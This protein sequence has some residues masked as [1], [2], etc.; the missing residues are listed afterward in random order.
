MK[1]LFYLFTFIFILSYNIQAQN[2]AL[3]LAG[4]D[5]YVSITDLNL[6]GFSALTFE[7]WVY[8]HTFNPQSPDSYISNILGQ[9]DESGLLRIG[10]DDAGAM[11]DNDRAQFVVKTTSGEKKCNGTT[12]MSTNRWY[13]LAGTYDGSNVKIY[14]NGVLEDTKAHSGNINSTSSIVLMG[15]TTSNNRYFDGLMDEVRI[16]SSSRTQEEIRQ[17]MYVELSDSEIGL[18]AYYKLNEVDGSTAVADAKGTYHGSLNNMSG[19]EWE[20]SSSFFGPKTCLELD[21]TDDYVDCGNGTG[22]QITGTEITLEAWINADNF[23]SNSHE[24]PIIDKH[25]LSVEGYTLRCGGSG[26]LSFNLGD[27]SSWYEVVSPTNSLSTNTWHHVAGVYD[28]TNMKIYVDGEEVNSGSTGASINDNGSNLSIGGAAE[29]PDR[30]FDGK[31]DE[32]R[33]W[34]VARSPSQIIE[35][36][37]NTLTGNESGLVAYYNFDNSSGELVQDFGHEDQAMSDGT[38]SGN[39]GGSFISP[40]W[41]SSA[42]FNTW[43]N[44]SSTSWSTGSNWSLG[45]YPNSNS[46]NVGIPDHSTAYDPEIT[47]VIQM[48]NLVV[49]DGA[50]LTFNHNGS[51]TIHG[52]VFNIGTT[53]LEANTDLTITGSLYMLHNS[54]LSIKELAF[55]TIDKNLYTTIWGLDGYLTVYSGPTGTGSLIVGGSSTGSVT[56]ER[57]LDEASRANTWHYVSSPVSGQLINTD[58]MTNNSIYSPDGGSNYSFYRWDEEQDYWI[59]FGS[60]GN[61]VAFNDTEFGNAKGYAITRNGAGDLSFSGTLRTGNTS[62]NAT[63]TADKGWGWNLAGNPFTSSLGVTD[64]ALTV[65]KFLDANNLLLDDN[66]EALYVWDEE[67]GYT[68]GDDDYKVISNAD[69]S[70]RTRIDQNY[71]QPGQAFMLK[72]VPGGGNFEFNANMMGHDNSEYYKSREYWPTFELGIQGMELNNIAAIGFNKDMTKGLDPSYDIGK[73]KGNPDIALYTRLVS[74]NGVDFA[75]QA[76][77]LFE[78][79]YSIPVGLD[80]THEGTYTFEA[81]SIDQIPDEIYIYLEDHKTNITT[82]LKESSSYTCT[83]DEPGSITNRFVLHFTQTAFGEEELQTHEDPIHIWTSNHTIN[84]YNPGHQKGSIRIFNLYGQ[85]ITQTKLD[86]SEQQ[87]IELQVPAAYYLVNVISNKKVLSKKVFVY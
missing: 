86:G 67:S 73:M 29:Y 25:G 31:I 78:E 42:A 49:G 8:P 13:H 33:V 56:F 87:Q 72:V 65:G 79:D 1:Y 32:V 3:E 76:L 82:D 44:A 2:N 7:A 9:T 85:Q 81:V 66:Y 53:N 28:G 6:D 62:F 11:Q 48:K 24:N 70:G 10:D 55:L 17:N 84:L 30:R 38:W 23:A 34:S 63:Y 12:Q 46:V 69:I 35:N 36:M 27:G 43:L 26:I 64:N 20:T 59:I 4:D 77:P 60:T 80:I 54:V 47:S 40:E 14:I 74:D 71:V 51:H 18:L 19:N 5:D 22:L 15:G 39:S 58:F 57:Y 75:I 41:T 50:T 21:G 68:Y 52:S 83:L 37:C 45:A 61:P 16:W